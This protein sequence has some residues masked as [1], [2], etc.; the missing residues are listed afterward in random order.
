MI[1]PTLSLDYFGTGITE[2][3]TDAAGSEFKDSDVITVSS[4][5]ELEALTSGDTP[6]VVQFSASWCGKCR[7]IQPVVDQL[8]V[9]NPTVKF[10]KV[11]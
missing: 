10:V 4:P 3:T 6:V 5:E 8:S 9:D 11:D 1:D 7:Q 2:E